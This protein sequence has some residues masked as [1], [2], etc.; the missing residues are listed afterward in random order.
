[1]HVNFAAVTVEFTSFYLFCPTSDYKDSHYLCTAD[2]ELVLKFGCILESFGKLK[3]L[4][5][6]QRAA[7]VENCLKM[8]FSN[9]FLTQNGTIALEAF[10]SLNTTAFA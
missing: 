7:K 1:M 9:Q 2:V 6:F 3:V 10:N 5:G 8:R 4:K